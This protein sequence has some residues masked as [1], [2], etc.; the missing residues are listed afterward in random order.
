[1]NKNQNET[2]KV[3]MNTIAEEMGVS[4]NTVFKALKGRAGISKELRNKIIQK[5]DELHYVVR[6]DI[7]KKNI[8]VLVKRELF[9]DQTYFA[10]IF[11]GIEENI[12]NDYKILFSILNDTENFELCHYIDIE[13]TAGIIIAGKSDTTV[14][15]KI[16][17]QR[18]PFVV[19]DHDDENC[20]ADVVIMMNHRGVQESIKM[21]KRNG[22]REIG[23]IGNV[24]MYCSFRERFEAYLSEM[25]RHH[26]ELKP[27]NVYTA[28]EVPFWDLKNLK[29]VFDNV[30]HFPTAFICVND[31]TAIAVIKYF[32]ERGIS[33]PEKL[34]I[35]GFDN[36]DESIMCVPSLTTVD[37]PKYYMG[38]KALELLLWRMRHLNDP[39][40][41]AEVG[42]HLE[43]RESVRCLNE[44]EK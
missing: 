35:V 16:T 20:P 44:S 38:Q 34:S 24:D 37:V 33:V 23:F 9:L 43:K 28:G 19:V 40:L 6:N 2:K 36:T 3:T 22:H 25:K 21:L 1:M 8:V 30:T 12:E 42:V 31:R 14:L 26:L 5:A 41:R 39:V 4:R 7:K 17:E 29:R 10:K 18:I 15:Q 32:S 11:V 13:E 27:Q